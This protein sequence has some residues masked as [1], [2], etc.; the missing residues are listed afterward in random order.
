MKKLSGKPFVLL[1][2]NSD[3]EREALKKTLADER[4]TWRSWW[5]DG[6]TDGPIHAAWQVTGRPANY[7]IDAAGVIRGKN[8]PPEE[9]E[10]AIEKLLKE[11]RKQAGLRPT[12]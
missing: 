12:K 9:V 8:I 4:I 3:N 1:G 6:R 5:D 10:Q 11:L 7:L 2:V